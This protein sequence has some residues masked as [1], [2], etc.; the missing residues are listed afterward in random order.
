MHKIG[1]SIAA[2]ALLIFSLS[3]FS[4][5]RTELPRIFHHSY[6]GFQLGFIGPPETD[7]F[8]KPGF[9]AFHIQAVGGFYHF[10]AG[11][12]FNPYFAI[13]A[14]GYWQLPKIEFINVNNFGNVRKM[15]M[16]AFSVFLKPTWP[17]MSSLS[18]FGL[19]GGGFVSRDGVY[20]P[21]FAFIPVGGLRSPGDW[22]NLPNLALIPSGV[23]P[24]GMIGGGV[25]ILPMSLFSIDLTLTYALAVK[26]RQ[27]PGFLNFGIGTHWNIP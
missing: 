25:S 3:A 24:T 10:Y 13:E 19:L 22:V 17:A 20:I 23:I 8:L 12:Y 14:G 18:V 27:F 9:T 7:A 16:S 26:S 15:S 4:D 6:I 5:N 11:H 21:N 1:A 2:L